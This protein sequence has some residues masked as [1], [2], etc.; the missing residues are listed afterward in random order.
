MV[1]ERLIITI[2]NSDQHSFGI[3]YS[4]KKWQNFRHEKTIPKSGS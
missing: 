3:E 4:K 2:S 1:Y